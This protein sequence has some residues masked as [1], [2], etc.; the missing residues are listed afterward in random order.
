MNYEEAIEFFNLNSKKCYTISCE[1]E[2][3]QVVNKNQKPQQ[4]V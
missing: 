3:K 4:I 2:M 1:E